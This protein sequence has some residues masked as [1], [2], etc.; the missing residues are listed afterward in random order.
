MSAP[1]TVS[2]LDL[3]EVNAD[4]TV[5]DTVVETFE[6]RF[7]ASVI[8]DAVDCGIACAQN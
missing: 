5:S 2:Q 7:E 4:P 3:E 8:H 1:A 6:V